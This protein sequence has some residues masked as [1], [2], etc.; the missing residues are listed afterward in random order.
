MLGTKWGRLG[1]IVTGMF[2]AT[3]SSAGPRGPLAGP[4]AQTRPAGEGGGRENRREGG[5]M[6]LFQMIDA[7]RDG[8]LQSAEIERWAE[9]LKRAGKA[10][11][12]GDVTPE[13]WGEITQDLRQKMHHGKG[14]KAGRPGKAGKARRGQ[15]SNAPAAGEQPNA[16]K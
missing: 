4:A 9:L 10:S 1:V 13:K 6:G 11:Q 12:E 8:K 3:S 15:Q 16:Q 14:D 7:N 5:P 2:L